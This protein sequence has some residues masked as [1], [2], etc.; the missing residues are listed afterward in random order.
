VG[1]RALPVL[2]AV[3]AAFADASGAHALARAAL[4][5]AVPLA[6]LAALGAFGRYVDASADSPTAVQAILSSAVLALL[7]LSCAVRSTALHGVPPLGAS[8]LGAVLVLYALKAVVTVV[9]HL[10]R[11]ADLW[12]SKP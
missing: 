2:L 4:L 12:P 3:L 7:V 1:R 9:P 5:V 10:R 8:S 11:V 6:A